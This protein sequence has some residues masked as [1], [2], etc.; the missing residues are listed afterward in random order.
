VVKIPTP[1]IGG[2]ESPRRGSDEDKEMQL[3]FAPQEEGAVEPEAAPADVDEQAPLEQPIRIEVEGAE[4]A[5][6]PLPAEPVEAAAELAEPDVAYAAADVDEPEPESFE[7][8]DFL[9]GPDSAAQEAASKA[10][11]AVEHLEAPDELAEI[12]RTLQDGDFG[13]RIRE[14]IQE[15]G[16]SA[17]DSAVP[18][19]FA[20]GYLAA[21]KSEEE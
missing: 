12:A 6:E 1:F 21:K 14:L 17:P 20:A 2:A 9:F 16:D 19:A 11:E 18:R 7:M 4:E 10:V 8:P 5:E 3:P 13:D 15:L